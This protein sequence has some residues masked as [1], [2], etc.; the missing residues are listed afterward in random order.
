MVGLYLNPDR[1]VVLCVDERSQIQALDRTQPVLPI[2]PGQVERRRHD[3]TRHG[4]T[5]LFAA[6]DAATGQVIGQCHRRHWAAEFRR[7][8]IRIDQAAP[9]HLD[10]H[11]I[12]DNYATHETPAILRWLARHPRFHLHF[13]PTG[14]SWLNLVERWF[15]ELTQ[16]QLRRGVHRSTRELVQAIQELL[17]VHKENPRPFVSTKSLPGLSVATTRP[18]RLSVMTSLTGTARLPPPLSLRTC[19]LARTGF[20]RSYAPRNATAQCRI[21]LVGR[22][23]IPPT[24]SRCRALTPTSDRSK[25]G[26][27]SAASP[28]KST[29]LSAGAALPS[30]ATAAAPSASVA[31]QGARV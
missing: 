27:V 5:S 26:R 7:A 17:D 14:S 13:T 9:R 3:Y 11:L 8:L 22:R 28:T 4:T 24:V 23:P 10:V 30:Q 21:E 20:C 31:S 15:P 2:R 18:W 25:C 1:A 19:R 12:L 29:L 16:K 6:L